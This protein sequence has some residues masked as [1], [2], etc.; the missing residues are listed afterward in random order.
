MRTDVKI[1][2]VVALL[3]VAVSGGYFMFRDDDSSSIPIADSAA[4]N[5]AARPAETSPTNS[6]TS[7]PRRANGPSR[8]NMT[9]SKP[10][11]ISRPPLVRSSDSPRPG[12]RPTTI[13]S[14]AKLPDAD[15]VHTVDRGGQPSVE[16]P[17]TPSSESVPLTKTEPVSPSTSD[18]EKS[19]MAGTD[20]PHDSLLRPLTSSPAET[21]R[22]VSMPPAANDPNSTASPK[23]SS[24]TLSALKSS[25]SPIPTASR[26]REVLDFS[27]AATDTHRVQPGDTL[28]SLAQEYYGDVRYSTFLVES[29]REL[30]DPNVLRSGTI[31]R[32]P[33][34]PADGTT[35]L[36]TNRTNP[37]VGHVEPQ[38]SSGKRYYTVRP[39]DSFYRIARTELG[40]ASRWKE[41]LALNSSLVHGDPTS[42]QP[43]QR[44]LLPES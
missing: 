36:A 28:S 42:L 13:P 14:A 4:R 30:T 44:L 20:Q 12:G 10:T 34:L 39:G 40:N 17:N 3:L 32:V 18:S 1:G 37:T 11:G 23:G 29:N 24:T 19:R 5:S 22:T 27:K 41:L 38:V 16:M 31:I 35:R 9:A 21:G 15:S 8:E 6:G 2:M 25:D 43:G 7:F 26:N 33:A